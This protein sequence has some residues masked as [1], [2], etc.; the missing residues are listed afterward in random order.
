MSSDC[1]PGIQN[2]H[3]STVLS[4]L[5]HALNDSDR[6]ASHAAAALINFAEDCNKDVMVPYI[7]SLLTKLFEK[8]QSSHRLVQEQVITAIASLA[9]CSSNHFKQYYAACMPILKN[10]LVHATAKEQRMLRAKSLE[11]ISLVGVAVGKQIFAEDAV[12]IMQIM[13]ELQRTCGGEDDPMKAYLLTAWMRFCSVLGSDFK[14]CLPLVMPTVLEYA[15]KAID[16]VEVAEDDDGED[17]EQGQMPLLVGQRVVRVRTSAIEDKIQALSMIASFA[18]DMKEAFF[19]FL[20][21]VAS[22]VTP[23]ILT[24]NS[25]HDDLRATAMASLPDLILC[26]ARSAE[27][28]VVKKLAD[29]VIGQLMVALMSEEELDNVKT[30]IQALKG[31]IGSAIGLLSEEQLLAIC[32]NMVQQISQS[33][34]RRAVAV[35]EKKAEALE[36]GEL[37]EESEQE[38]AIKAAEEEELH[39]LISETLAS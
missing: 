18:H 11:C 26:A 14:Q 17:F 23:L 5:I 20:E 22:V 12:Q 28:D 8:L 19:P 39:F 13:M 10:I 4:C 29:Y 35:A 34:Q 9:E 33:M 21:Q 7:E 30:A 1:S 25:P 15:S 27:R 24:A 2:N 36:D 6:V 16:M 32:G 37:D 31:C 38:L 3:H